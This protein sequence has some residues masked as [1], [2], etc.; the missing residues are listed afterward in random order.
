MGHIEIYSED[1][2]DDIFIDLQQ[3]Q[4]NE[5]FHVIPPCI[6]NL[7]KNNVLPVFNMS[8]SSVQYKKG[9]VVARGM[10]CYEN[11]IPSVE[12]LTAQVE[13]VKVFTTQDIKGQI[14]TDLNADQMSS[15]LRILNEYRDCFATSLR[16]IGKT[17]VTTMS[18]KMT[19][20]TPVTYR[21]YR[22]AF[23]NREKV[24]SIVQDLLDNGII[25]ESDSPYASPI[26]L[27]K[28]KNG[29]ER[30]CVDYRAVNRKTIKDK[31][32]LPRIDDLL[33][34]IQ[35]NKFFTTLDLASGYHQIPIDA[36]SVSKTAFVTPDGHFE[37]LR[38]PFG[39]ANAPAVF[40]RAMNKILGPLR[41]EAMA[42]I[43]DVLI[44]SRTIS[45][46]LEKLSEVLKLFRAAN[47]T[48]RLEKCRFLRTT[49][50]YLGHEITNE[51]IRPGKDQI[52]AV[53]DFPRPT[54]VHEVR[55]FL[56]LTSYF[57]KFIKGLSN[58]SKPL[59]SLTKKDTAF[60]WNTLEEEAFKTLKEKLVQRPVL[61]MYNRNAVTEV[62]CDASKVGLGAI[63]LQE[64]VDGTLKPV[65]YFSK[66]TTPDEQKFHSYELETLAVVC[67][68]KKIQSLLAGHKIQ[69]GH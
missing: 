22:M 35:G 66:S 19:D 13:D 7:K 47:M 32:P 20:Y 41:H 38:M 4:W 25:Q 63:L 27:V 11:C 55:R 49:I 36:E 1:S 26:L 58:I 31:Y 6:L 34:N 2:F 61:A 64:Q 39:L 28:K 48:L 21:P 5:N 60:S 9:Q 56:G 17:N 46:G 50:E 62:H 10:L 44:P 14:D 51:G 29:E 69:G 33:D 37:Y 59:T 42:Y 15:L 43:N 8:N 30:M 23:A 16:E 18:I 54:D 57:R 52:K 53:S 3:R 67:A 12:C 65:Q 24:R 40:Q 45:P 68:L